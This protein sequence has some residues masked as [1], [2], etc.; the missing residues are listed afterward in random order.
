MGRRK[1]DS[2]TAKPDRSRLERRRRI[3]G[4]ICFLWFGCVA[5]RLYYF[6]VI[7]YVDWLTRAQRQQQ[8]TIEVAPQRGAIYDR[9]MNPL[10]M[11]LGVDSIYAVP[12]ELTE[13]QMV[14]SLLAP[15][16]GLDGDDLRN[17]FQTQHSFC[18]VKRRVT[19]EEAARVRELNLKGIYSQ[20]ET[21]RFYPKAELAAQ[22]IGYVGLDDR[23]LGGI[24]YALDNEIKGKPGRVLLDSDARRR[25]FHSTEWEGVPGKSVILTLDEKI[26]YITEKALQ[27]EVD[28]GQAAGGVAIVQNPNTGEIL[29]LANV[30]TFDPNNFAAT[31]AAARLDRAVGW[32]YEPGSTFKLVTLSAALEEKLTN[33]DEIINC[34]NGSIV[35][36]G[37]TIHDHKRYGDLS[38]TD[39]V[40]NSSD[41]G[42]IKLGLRLGEERFFRYIQAYGFGAKTDV[43]LPGEERGLL[44]PPSRWSGISIGEMSMGQEVGVTP[45]QMVTAYSTVANGGILFQPRIVHDVFLAN[46]HDSLAPATG[47]RV[48]SARTA[49]LVRQILTAVVDHGTGKMGQLGGYTSAGKTGTAQ[50]IDSNG[51]YSKSHYVASFIGFAPATRPAVTILV[52]IDSPVGGHHGGDVAGPV[53]RSIAEQTLSYLNVPQDN[54]SHWPQV[55]PHNPAKVPDQKQQD[56]VGFLPS[57]REP[58]G[59]ATSPVQ[60]AS[61]SRGIS[62]EVPAS[63]G[64]PDN[65]AAS[66]T[67]VL[68]DGPLVTVPDFSGWAVRRVAEKCEKL[69]LDLNAVGSGLAVEQNPAPGLKVPSG[70][71]VW[72]RMRR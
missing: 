2:R 12:S 18:W 55:K 11:S 6:Q 20:R 50:K 47:R 25:A 46:H 59:S 42:A 27:E 22:A 8:R 44:K 14:A 37:H 7:H 45:L 36:A 13:P 66:T 60:S 19:R 69:G 54:P 35:L 52:V 64:S 3:V 39:V 31:S 24:E 65:G 51:L 40:A 68:G 26:Q 62:P 72:V 23:G 17:R 57:D 70:T 32:V 58:F 67:V 28:R 71:R 61:Y 34:Q 4:A 56:F 16:L 29:A 33:P 30:P 21:K 53:F 38:V 41:V 48:V 15:V 5:A 43:D 63:Q 10:A 49:Q 9:Q 1:S